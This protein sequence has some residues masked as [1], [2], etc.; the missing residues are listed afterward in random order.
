MITPAYS[1]VR[2]VFLL[3]LAEA[4][5]M[6]GFAAYPA[7]L[8]GL[9]TAWAMSD[10]E[11]GFVGG[12]FFFGYMVAVP[13][14]S[15]MTDR[16]DAR[17]VFA[18]SCL[19]TAAGA[20]G[21]GLLAQGV[22]SGA[23]WQA[24]AGAGLAGTYMP[25][26]KALTDRAS[27]PRLPRY[28]AFYTATFGLGTSLSLL[29][30]GALARHF[31]WEAAF[32]FLALGPLAA[33]AIVQWGLAP[34]QH[35]HSGASSWWPRLG[36]VVA[37]RATR[38]FILGYAAH[39]WELLGLRSWLV[40]FIAF[41][42]AT[43]QQVPWLTATEAG[44]LINL[45]GLPASILGN[46]A[47]GKF[48]RLRWIAG[49]MVVAGLLCWCAGAAALLPWGWMLAVLSIYFISITADSAALTAGL[50]TTSPPS[51]LG[52][53]MALHSLAGFGAGFV[54][55][56]CFGAVLD[57]GGGH[58]SAEAWRWAFGTLG[59]WGL[60]WSVMQFRRRAS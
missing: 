25:G 15:G 55:P 21:F 40:A 48:G 30:A 47:A 11:A 41:A 1:Q 38:R 20:A 60:L 45:L 24:L 54:A 29:W 49:V 6:A 51:Q 43:G 37:N 35:R 2:I 9:R 57:L 18:G 28:I 10:T 4:L 50:V 7:F 36:P 42:F 31:A 3:C 46:E 8:P 12:A 13:F 34:R 16:I 32:G 26:L 33:G 5:S 39:C 56:L 14:L 44:A 22:L 27:G 52:A 19:L 23:F 59:V 58:E 53:A 17:K